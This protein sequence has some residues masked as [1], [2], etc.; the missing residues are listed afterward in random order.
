MRIDEIE[1]YTKVIIPNIEREL[2]DKSKSN[3]ELL[4]LYNLYDEVL[5]M[6]APYDFISYN[7]CLEFEE[8]KTNTNKGFYHHRKY[9][10][11]ELFDA[12]NDMEIYD[13]YDML[14]VSMP[15]RV[16]K[17]TTGIRYL[18]W[19]MGRYPE[20]TQLATSYSDSVTTS[21]YG[22][23]MEILLEDR[24]NKIFPN[25]PLI[26]QNAKRQEIWLKVLKRYPT[27]AFIS[28]GGSMAG[29]GQATNVLYVD[30]IVS[31]LE[32]SLS[33]SR[34]SK[35]WDLYS[36]NARQRKVEGAKEVHVSTKWSVR[37]VIC[38]L[39]EQHKDNPRC[40]ILNMPC[41][42]ENGESNFNF[43]GGFSTKYYNDMEDGMDKLSFGALY[44]CEPVER[45]GLLYHEEDLQYYFDLPN[46]EPDAIISV[47]DSKNLGKDYVASPIGYVYGDFIY[48]EDV[49]YNNGLPEVTVPLIGN[50]WNKHKVTR[51]DIELN[52]GG[53]YYAENVEKHIKSLGGN[54]S[55]RMFFT[56][57]NKTVKIITYSDFV[58]KQFIFKDKSKYSPNSEYA[59][60]MKNVFTW[61]QTV[62][63]Q[64]DDAP[65]SLAMLAQLVQDLQGNSV[66]VLDRR[67]LGI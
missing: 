35:L 65:D 7:K 3:E 12:L 18:S 63:S 34:M 38:I 62:K 67:K 29:R 6:I 58:S 21:F 1:Q 9:H 45:E 2:T 31:G 24:F 44:M 41:Y 61:S 20:S 42:D 32:E 19:I 53:N 51:G 27:I 48:I 33:P 52:N 8:D 10:L 64:V 14:L 16:G 36:V 55:I 25:T 56:G 50:L 39:A 22:G 11:S 54:T 26:N 46:E 30:D 49:I 13:K 43:N 37:D 59:N 4:E 15:P 23:V 40:K 47:C 57:N 66:K 28:I 5:T 60:F 17:T